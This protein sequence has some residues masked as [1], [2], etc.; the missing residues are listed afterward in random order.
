MER[1]GLLRFSAANG[2]AAAELSWGD[3]AAPRARRLRLQRGAERGEATRSAV[4]ISS[5]RL[6]SVLRGERKERGLF[7]LEKIAEIS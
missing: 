2:E 7:S 3:A 6:Q 5:G 1:C 4:N